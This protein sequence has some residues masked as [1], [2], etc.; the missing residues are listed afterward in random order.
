MED[1]STFGGGNLPTAPIVLERPLESAGVLA[2]VLVALGYQ[3]RFNELRH[4]W[5]WRVPKDAAWRSLDG[6]SAFVA[7]IL[8]AIHR[9]FEFQRSAK[10]TLPVVLREQRFRELLPGTKDLDG[11]NRG[12]W[13]FRAWLEALPPWNGVERLDGLLAACFELEDGQDADFVAF[14]SRY[15]H[16]ACVHRA[17]EPRCKVEGLTLLRGEGGCGKSTFW[18]HLMPEA[19][20]VDAHGARDSWFTDSLALSDAP[21]E[22]VE[23]CAG[24]VLGEFAE[25]VGSGVAHNAKIKA[26]LS[27]E[28]DT[29]RLA[30]RRDAVDYPR[31][32]VFCGSSDGDGAVPNDANTRRF[33]PVRV[34]KRWEHGELV[35]WLTEHREQLWAEA[36]HRYRER[37]AEPERAAVYPLP[38]M[39]KAQRRACELEQVGDLEADDAVRRFLR[40]GR[41]AYTVTQL[42]AAPV[43]AHLNI[44]RVRRALSPYGWSRRPIR[45]SVGGER[46]FH[47]YVYARRGTHNTKLLAMWKKGDFGEYGE[48]P[49]ELE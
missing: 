28:F 41:D 19:D 35:A 6:D 46:K 33:H 8:E 27:R 37:E 40:N 16:L 36:L 11:V 38:A 23:K 39:A 5:E 13:P 32:V 48:K 18:R 42:L 10:R 14:A 24:K 29:V 31:I 15:T 43:L 3:W 4:A 47:G 49:Y 45:E 12:V 21:K 30:W 26:M 20:S 25:M 1:T 17:F 44:N 22:M 2:Q 7:G 34:A 9:N